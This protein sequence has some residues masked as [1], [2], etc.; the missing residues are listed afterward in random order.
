LPQF[1]GGDDAANKRFHDRT[2]VR[3]LRCVCQSWPQV[4]FDLTGVDRTGKSQPTQGNS[5]ADERTRQKSTMNIRGLTMQRDRT[6]RYASRSLKTR[7]KERWESAER[8]AASG[9]AVRTVI[10]GALPVVLSRT[11]QVLASVGTKVREKK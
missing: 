1:V 8:I 4:Q 9:R 7:S 2:I 3:F 10:A 5:A 6:P 11:Q